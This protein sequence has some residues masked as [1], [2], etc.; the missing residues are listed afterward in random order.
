[1]CDRCT[2]IGGVR[3]MLDEGET[4]PVFIL[5]SDMT[6]VKFMMWKNTHSVELK[7]FIDNCASEDK[8]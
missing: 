3:V 7:E 5:P 8:N 6:Q 1:M 2:V 4:K